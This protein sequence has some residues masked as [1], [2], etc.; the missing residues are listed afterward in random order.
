MSGGSTIWGGRFGGGPSEIMEEINASIGFDRRLY[1]QDIAASMAHC[2]MLARAGIISEADAK[3]ILDGLAK[4]RDEIEAG[5]FTFRRDLEDIHMNV[6]SRLTDLIGEAAG[7]LHT[8]RSR[9]D[10][11]ATDFKLWVRDAFDRLDLGLQALQQA[12]I[13]RA[14]TH[15]ADVL[16]GFTHLQSAQPV[17]LGHHLLAYVEMT[18]RDRGRAKDARARMNESPLGAAA[19]AGT[20]FPIDREM[21]AREMGFDRP[22][23]NSLDAVSD[24]DFAL[25]YLSTA[26]IAATHLSRLAEEMVIWSSAQFGFVK[27]PDS[28]STGSS[29]MPQKR[30]PDAAE[31]VR[32]KAGRVIGDLNALLIVMKGLPLAYSKDMQDDKEPLFEAADT[33][34]LC[35][36]AMTGM[37]TDVTF[38]TDRMRASTAL[39]F[40]TATDLA[41]WLVRV[42][43]L[44]FR[45]AHHVT[46]AL[47]KMAEDRGIDLDQ[48]SLQ[49]MQTVEPGITE[50]LF[51]VLG[52]ASSVASRTSFGGTA[53]DNV[54][55]AVAEARR[56]F[57]HGEAG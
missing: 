30:N 51:S 22:C 32:A 49:D 44:P 33:L 28:F 2:R 19:L 14:E 15:A 57:L 3:S 55:A 29:I 24:R 56:R 8:A 42:L 36:A 9:N 21:T 23:A 18:G 41:D 31:L 50:D 46:G 12:L 39:G 27:L 52:V 5:S 48:L 54:R 25:E 26:A 45:Q 43:G 40:I 34:D 38:D 35:L 16:P 17:T 1:A 47:V 20:S 13:D 10:Q 53:P 7:R 37:I 11:V 6:E 4:I